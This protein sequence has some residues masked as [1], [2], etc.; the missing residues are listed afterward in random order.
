MA[1]VAVTVSSRTPCIPY[2]ATGSLYWLRSHANI[3][4][5][6]PLLSG[7]S[8][9]RL[10]RSPLSPSNPSPLSCHSST[11]TDQVCQDWS[12]REFTGKIQLNIVRM[13]EFLNKFGKRKREREDLSAGARHNAAAN[14]MHDDELRVAPGSGCG[15]DGTSLAAQRTPRISTTRNGG[16]AM[17][18][19]AIEEKDSVARH[20]PRRHH[21]W[22]SS[23]PPLPLSPSLDSNIYLTPV[24]CT[25]ILN[26]ALHCR[27]SSF[28]LFHSVDLSTRSR[29]AKI[30]EKLTSLERS[31]EYVSSSRTH[32][33]LLVMICD[34]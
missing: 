3:P 30:N 1:A 16:D 17:A 6:S 20:G 8:G 19:G 23:L 13:V 12:N 32:D 21:S 9:S 18:H 34:V 27:V 4:P 11:T 33:T 29:L 10:T 14:T 26:S 28:C 24:S 31:L 2:A 5:P 15:I 22:L 7:A 25:C